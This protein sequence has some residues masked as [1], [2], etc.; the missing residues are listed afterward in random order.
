MRGALT[1]DLSGRVAVVTGAG[2]GIGRAVALALAGQGATVVLA[3]RQWA[4]LQALADEI[5]AG[6]RA[7][8]ALPVTCDVADASQVRD[9]FQQVFKAFRRLDVLVA[10]AGLMEDAPIGMV[11]PALVERVFGTNSAGLLY[12][13]Q[14]ASR[15]M[16][17][18]GAGGSIVALSSVVGLQGHAGQ[19]VYAG[20]K[21]AVLGIVAALAREL[22]PQQIRVNAIAPGWIDTELTAALPAAA[23]EATLARIG[24]QRAGAPEDVAATALYL[25]SDLSRY[26]TG[27]VI[28]VDGGLHF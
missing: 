21:A 20:S 3:G 12:C 17:R 8:A 18:G 27:Q 16:A 14:Y 13:A 2:R 4:P 7:D 1:L 11:T 26:V 24:L 9:L 10:N 22:A 28:G 25:A 5:Q 15:L 23:R 6:G 19:S